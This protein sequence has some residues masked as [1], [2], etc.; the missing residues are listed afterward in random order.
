MMW[1]LD[2]RKNLHISVSLWSFVFW[3]AF[4]VLF[5]FQG[6]HGLHCGGGG[7][8][9]WSLL[10]GFVSSFFWFEVQGSWEKGSNDGQREMGKESGGSLLMSNLALVHRV[11]WR[12]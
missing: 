3:I 12:T 5:C 7:W 4:S 8:G 2:G 9:L 10:L 11:D 1:G 6:V